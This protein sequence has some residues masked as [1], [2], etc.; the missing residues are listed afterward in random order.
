MCY[1]ESLRRSC[2]RDP[3]GRDA[4]GFGRASRPGGDG[5]VHWDGHLEI[6][7]PFGE[8]LASGQSRE[9]FIYHELA[10][11]QAVSGRRRALR[12]AYSRL[13]LGYFVLRYLSTAAGYV[14]GS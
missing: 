10:F 11:D 1:E 4:P 5:D 13:S 9:Q 12:R 8:V 6:I 3:P 14:S 2:G 7:D